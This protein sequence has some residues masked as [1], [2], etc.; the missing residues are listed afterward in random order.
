LH[1]EIQGKFK[2][3]T[4]EIQ[5]YFDNVNLEKKGAIVPRFQIIQIVK[6]LKVLK[7]SSSEVEIVESDFAIYFS[8]EIEGSCSVSIRDPDEC[9]SRWW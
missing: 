2:T 5:G 3:N 9:R 8:D 6:I 1:L 7:F 4:L